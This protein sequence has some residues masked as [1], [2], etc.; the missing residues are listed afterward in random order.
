MV[1]VDVSDEGTPLEAV[2]S[3]SKGSGTV[4]DQGV[5]CGYRCRMRR[6]WIGVGTCRSGT[7]RVGTGV[8][9]CRSGK[10]K[11]WTGIGTRGT[12]R[13][14]TNRTETGMVVFPDYRGG[15]W[16]FFLSRVPGFSQRFRRLG[17]THGPSEITV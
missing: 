8:G 17:Y 15:H 2:G 6:V 11:V 1:S 12:G 5:G 10:R 7:G 4:E 16:S 13:T 3:D 14:R 9:T